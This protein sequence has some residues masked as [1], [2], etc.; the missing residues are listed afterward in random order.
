MA[1]RPWIS[2][3]HSIALIT[4][5]TAS[6]CFDPGADVPADTDDASTGGTMSPTEPTGDPPTTSSPTS[7]TSS[8][9]TTDDTETTDDPTTGGPGIYC[10]DADEDGF[11]NPDNCDMFEQRPATY[12]DDDTDCD[13]G[14]AFAFP[15]AAAADDESAC[16][17]DADED[18][19]GDQ[20][21][22]G[23]VAAG[24]DCD[25]SENFTFPGAAPNDDAELC[26]R[27][28]DDD[29]YADLNPGSG[30]IAA[31]TD[32]VDSDANAF[33]GAA[34]N[35]DAV[36]CMM[37][38]DGD[39]WGDV[40]GPGASVPGT[41][42]DDSDEF[43]FPGAAPN[44]DPEACMTDAD[45][46]DWGDN[47]PGGS[48]VAG[49]DCADANEDARPGAAANEPC[50]C[51]IDAD[52]DGWGD[53]D[54]VSAL[55]DA[56]HDCND[57]NDGSP[58]NC[59]PVCAD[60]DGDGVSVYVGC[61]DH[62]PGDPIPA[63]TALLTCDCLDT[64]AFAFPGAAPNDDALACMRDQDGDNWGDIWPPTAV[65]E[66]GT[67]C[68]DSASFPWPYM[69]FGAIVVDFNVLPARIHPEAA[70]N[71]V[72]VECQLD[73][74]DD[75]FASTFVPPPAAGYPFAATAWIE[76]GTDADDVNAAVQ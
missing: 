15:G 25:D 39:D 50:L 4:L 43:A 40:E 13:D 23:A 42:C 22:M 49:T 8:D 26:M 37:D 34:P 51:A 64:D 5:A 62:A 33:P 11:G 53:S 28:Q 27:D 21:A 55:V 56:G 41:D 74:D 68:V 20:F 9:P 16:M 67:D 10:E 75:G 70:Q 60:E 45:D 54:P 63:G 61:I 12:V 44:D 19:F 24:S 47:M 52:T 29:D 2:Q 65:I 38:A 66:P 17:R 32:C 3:L 6:G 1:G 59:G 76:A 57:G 48:G 7:P 73:Y 46:D 72:S 31:G 58:T 30:D 36:L 35:D 18:D 69:A 71:E 14:D